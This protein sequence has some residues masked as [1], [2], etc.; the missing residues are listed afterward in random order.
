MSL[1]MCP[2]C[3]NEVSD[4]AASCPKCG[5][6]INK[7]T[8]EERESVRV[9]RK[10]RSFLTFGGILFIVSMIFGIGTSNEELMLRTR[11]LTSGLYGSEKIKWLILRYV[12]DLILWISII[13][14]IIGVIYF[15]SA[16]KRRK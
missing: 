15:I 2:E 8:E 16:K 11:K 9:K 6:L 10:S 3:G 14:V 5:Y 1:I 7:V 13:L 4:K 12:P